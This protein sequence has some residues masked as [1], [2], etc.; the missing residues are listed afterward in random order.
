MLVSLPKILVICREKALGS[1]GGGV[2]PIF[3]YGDV[4]IQSQNMDSLRGATPL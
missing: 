4:R 3:V 1:G 2:L